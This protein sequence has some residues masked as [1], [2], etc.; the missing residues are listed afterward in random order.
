[1]ERD[2]VDAHAVAIEGLELREVPVREVGLLERLD[3]TGNPA[4]R[5]QLVPR[6]ASALAIDPLAKRRVVPPQILVSEVRRHVHDFVG[7]E[8]GKRPEGGH[9]EDSCSDGLVPDSSRY[10]RA[11][12][13]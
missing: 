2:L 9:R 13:S 8:R 3:R 12:V 1:M 10:T 11:A 7:G 6:P 4:E 5:G